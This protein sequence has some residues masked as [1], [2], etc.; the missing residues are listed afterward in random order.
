MNQNYTLTMFQ[1]ISLS[2]VVL[3][4][5][6]CSEND[7]S[8]TTKLPISQQ[9]SQIPKDMV[10]IPAGDFIMGSD[11]IDASG[12]SEEFGFNEPWFLNEHPQRK[13]YLDAFYIDKYEATNG[14]Y[15]TFLQATGRYSEKEVSDIIK[16]FGLGNE[17][18]PLRNVTWHDANSFCKAIG[19]R[20]P[21]EAE[22]EKAARG[23]K[24][25]E[26]PWSN[27]WN[28]DYLNAGG[29]EIDVMPVGS[30]EKGKS[31]YGV[32]DMAGNVMEWVEDWYEAYPGAKYI[33]P[34]YGK[35]RKVV[36]GG[37]WG[38]IGHYVIP[39]FFRMAY[40]YNYP[41]DKAFN[42]IGFRCAR[43]VDPEP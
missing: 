36:R 16:K 11:D 22:W 5:G 30:Y 28:P 6:A 42:D 12:K 43:D 39:H 31:P 23:E 9:A 15:K 3:L 13:V 20:L 18:D 7:K 40:R 29:E 32:Y 27:E 4:L 1:I 17:K 2:I 14:D 38:G 35:K 33:S 25:L 26:F 8:Q 21:T 10:L 19:K 41:A 24:G 34:R 37:G